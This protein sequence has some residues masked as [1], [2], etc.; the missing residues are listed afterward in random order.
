[1]LCGPPADDC[2]PISCWLFSQCITHDRNAGTQ[3]AGLQNTN[4][5]CFLNATL[6]CLIHTPPLAEVLLG[7]RQWGGLG[8]VN[9]LSAMQQLTKDALEKRSRSLL[10]LQHIRALRA[11]MPRC[12]LQPLPGPAVGP[13]ALPWMMTHLLSERY[14]AVMAA[15]AAH[16][17]SMS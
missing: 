15:R 5:T 13:A 6:Q 16:E 17:P 3:G 11:L 9:M 10:P 1:M 7:K 2:W 8:P 14:A 12:G 4:N